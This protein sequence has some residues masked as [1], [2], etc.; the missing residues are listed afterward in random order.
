MIQKS[1]KNWRIERMSINDLN[2]IRIATY[3]MMFGEMTQPSVFINE[4]VELA[5]SFGSDKSRNFVNGMLQQIFD[6]NKDK[7]NSL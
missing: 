3:E 6:D 4:A 1:S 2:I 7:L 5:K